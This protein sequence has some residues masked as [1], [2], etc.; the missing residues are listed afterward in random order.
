MGKGE[1]I[2]YQSSDGQTEL[3]VRLEGD[4]VW[5]SQAQLS[6]LFN[7]DRTSVGRHIR[8]IYKSGELEENATCA[9]FAQVQQEGKR[10]VKRTIPYYNLD[11]VISVGYRVNSKRAT[12]FRIWANRVLKEYL[13]KGYAINH[14]AKAEQLEELK[15]T[16]AVMNDVLAA[17]SVTKEEAIGLLRVISDFAYGLDTLDRYDYQ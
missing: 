6:S 5:L 1:I 10:T 15:R 8:N 12:Q 11:I 3:D 16:I 7:S 9:F 14:N 4:S 2:I 17:K 13:I